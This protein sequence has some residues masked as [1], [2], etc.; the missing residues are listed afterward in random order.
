MEKSV[1]LWALLSR[2]SLDRWGDGLLR[3]YM[4]NAIFVSKSHEYAVLGPAPHRLMAN[5]VKIL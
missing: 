3:Q 5:L 2:N 4:T 1:R